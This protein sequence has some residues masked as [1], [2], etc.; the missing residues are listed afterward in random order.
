MHDS[1]HSLGQPS[2]RTADNTNLF[3]SQ[4]TSNALSAL[5]VIDKQ[6]SFP[7]TS[8]NSIMALDNSAHSP[9]AK[10]RSDDAG[11]ADGMHGVITPRATSSD[12]RNRGTDDNE[13]SHRI[14]VSARKSHPILVESSSDQ[15]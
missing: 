12:K 11:G 10:S 1:L 4:D 6:V 8:E 3:S 9:A 14:I 13:D 2:A 15:P 5:N 7:Q